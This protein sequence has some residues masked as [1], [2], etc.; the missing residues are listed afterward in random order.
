MHA[1][2]TREVPDAVRVP[3]KEVEPVEGSQLNAISRLL[4]H[5]N[6]QQWRNRSVSEIRSCRLDVFL[7]HVK[8]YL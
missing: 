4:T 2:W 6:L 1:W 8:P 7:N 5:N 3:R